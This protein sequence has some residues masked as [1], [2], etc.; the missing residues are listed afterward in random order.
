MSDNSNSYL[1]N[2]CWRFSHIWDD[3]QYIKSLSTI[4]EQ[5]LLMLE[6]KKYQSRKMFSTFKLQ[7]L[8]QILEYCTKKC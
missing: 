8:E 5:T 1:M 7:N 2:Y 4:V 3:G 6:I